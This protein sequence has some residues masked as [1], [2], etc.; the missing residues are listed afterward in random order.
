MFGVWGRP[1]SCD[2]VYP[3]Q[4]IYFE[5]GSPQEFWLHIDSDAKTR[6][7][8]EIQEMI[9]EASNVEMHHLLEGSPILARY[10]VDSRVYRA[11]IVK[12]TDNGVTVR[13]IDYGNLEEGLTR[14]SLYPWDPSLEVIAA[15]ALMCRFSK[16]DG[17]EIPEKLEKTE[18]S[19]FVKQ[20]RE[21]AFRLVVRKRL[22]ESNLPSLHQESN[23][24]APEMEVSLY[25][26]SGTNILTKLSKLLRR[27]FRAVREEDQKQ[28]LNHHQPDQLSMRPP[29]PLHLTGEEVNVEEDEPLSPLPSSIVNRAIDNVFW[30][31][32]HK[33]DEQAT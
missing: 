27:K 8:E 18:T 21:S 32:E 28:Q 22:R 17:V 14:Y 5:E 7:Q 23:I 11:R 30:W 3:E 10:S 31:F 15:Q 29:P 33:F 20:M 9:R 24:E 12:L 25:T 26:K 4:R 19:A 1:L 2:A 16:F 6:M 13:Y